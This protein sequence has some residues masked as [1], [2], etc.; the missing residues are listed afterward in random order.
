MDYL[1]GQGVGLVNDIRPAADVVR[2]LVEGA[3]HIL[4]TLTAAQ[5]P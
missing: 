1:A 3:R 5:D 2:E 4:S